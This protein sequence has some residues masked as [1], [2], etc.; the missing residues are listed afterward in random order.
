MSGFRPLKV[1]L[2]IPFVLLCVLFFTQSAL[3]MFE[4]QF[5]FFPDPFLI[6]TPG[7]L[8][9]TYEEVRLK[10]DDGVVLHGWYVPGEKSAPLILFFHGNAGN[11]SHR[12]DNLRL[13]RRLGAAVLIFDYRGYGRSG[14]KADEEGLYRDGRAALAW[15]KKRGWKTS[16]VVYFGRSLGAGPAVQLALEDPPA[17]LV[18]ESPIPSVASMGRHHYPGLYQLI[19]WLVSARF[20]VL[21]KIGR[22]GVPLLVFQGEND[23]IVTPEMGRQ[24]FERAR[25]PKT[26]F[27]IPGA[28][29]NDTYNTGGKPYWEAWRSF[30][31]R[32]STSDGDDRRP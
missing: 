26:F 18:L 5:L 23:F 1:R 3:A 21:E 19:G 10:T 11:I 12:L 32:I 4:H 28:G 16:R 31:G 27:L 15:L 6:G 29:H 20:D 17:G 9:L 24:V 14:G 30:L 8:G 13:F 2:L 22:V 7:D 25:D